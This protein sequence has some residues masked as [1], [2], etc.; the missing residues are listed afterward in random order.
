MTSVALLTASLPERGGLLAE[1]IASAEA[2]TRPPELHLVLIDEERKGPGPLYNAAAELVDTE[3]IAILDDDDLLYPRHLEVLLEDSDGADVVHSAFDVEGRDG[4]DW[5]DAHLF[6]CSIVQP[7]HNGIPVT[8]LIRREIF[9]EV[10]G[11]GTKRPEDANLWRAIKAAGGRFE[12]R[13]ERTWVYRF[14][15]K[16]RS[17][18]RRAGADV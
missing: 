7:G 3:W 14:H 18:R 17:M 15:G 16:N 4:W 5:Q 8:A 13:H 1:A 12:C 2:Q 11:F 10:G 9:L 6:G